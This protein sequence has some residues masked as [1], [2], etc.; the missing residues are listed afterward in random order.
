LRGRR[1]YF[2]WLLRFHP[3]LSPV[4]LLPNNSQFD[5]AWDWG[6]QQADVMM[7]FPKKALE[8]AILEPQ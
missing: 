4:K 1:E 3:T 7:P 5:Q 8:P 2:D 6:W